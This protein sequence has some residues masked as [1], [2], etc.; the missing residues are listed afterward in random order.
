M[1]MMGWIVGASGGWASAVCCVLGVA[2]ERR[3]GPSARARTTCYNN[4]SPLR[5][6]FLR[7]RSVR[8]NTMYVYVYVLMYKYVYSLSLSLSQTVTYLFCFYFGARYHARNAN[9]KHTLPDLPL[10][11]GPHPQLLWRSSVSV[12]ALCQHPCRP[13]PYREPPGRPR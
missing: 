7:L 1:L 12:C 5:S 10:A 11:R 4:I 3:H 13:C 8:S 6:R 2:R 9:N